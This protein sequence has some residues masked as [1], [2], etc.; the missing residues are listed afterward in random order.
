MIPESSA[1]PGGAPALPAEKRLPSD[2]LLNGGKDITATMIDGTQRVVKV[3]VVKLSEAMRYYELIGS[4]TEF[5]DWIT[6]E[7]AGF[8][9]TLDEDSAYAID[10]IAKDLNDFRCARFLARQK[11]TRMALAGTAQSIASQS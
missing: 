3:R 4:M 6:G 8:C 7:A 2:V 9:D 11:A 10:A 5:V 1:E